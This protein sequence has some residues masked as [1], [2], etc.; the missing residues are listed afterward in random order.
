MP[1]LAEILRTLTK[2]AARG[3]RGHPMVTVAFYGPTNEVASKVVVALILEADADPVSLER[4]FSHEGDVR[5]D[6]AAMTQVHAFVRTHNPTTVGMPNV[7]IGC[8]HE[9]G[10]DYPEGTECPQ[11]PFWRGRDRW[12]E[13][14]H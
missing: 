11:C 9:E 4:A 2:K 7:I 8:P 14:P 10:I 6:L 13:L 5:A 12:K 3:Y 1:N